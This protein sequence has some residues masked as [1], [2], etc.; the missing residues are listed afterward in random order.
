MEVMRRKGK[1][2]EKLLGSIGK[3]ADEIEQGLESDPKIKTMLA[4]SGLAE[5]FIFT[6]KILADVAEKIDSTKT[7][8]QIGE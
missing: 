6:I 1:K 2:I 8:V 4:D 5:R 3:V 7:K